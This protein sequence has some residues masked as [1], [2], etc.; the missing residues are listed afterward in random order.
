MT[1][2]NINAK[3]V[4][5]NGVLNLS[6]IGA[7]LFRGKLTGTAQINARQNPAAISFKPALS[8]V[9]VGDALEQ[10][11]GVGILSATGDVALDL[12]MRGI[13]PEQIMNSLSGT[14]SLDLLNG[15]IKGIDL[16]KIAEEGLSLQSLANLKNQSWWHHGVCYREDSVFCERRQHS[17]EQPPVAVGSI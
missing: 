2:S 12:S 16:R 14:G 3:A 8:K 17:I 7:E 4:S 6:N 9:A 15:A 10:V 13:K 1:V 11:L 5:R